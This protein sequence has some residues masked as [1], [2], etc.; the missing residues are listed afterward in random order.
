MPT[1]T[2]PFPPSTLQQQLTA[3]IMS[4]AVYCMDDDDGVD[5]VGSKCPSVLAVI[6]PP[7][8]LLLLLQNSSR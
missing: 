6:A 4:K 3:A 8:V 5:N 1:N 2:V 7:F